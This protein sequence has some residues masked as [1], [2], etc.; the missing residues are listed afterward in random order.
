MRIAGTKAK[1]RGRDVGVGALSG[2]SAWER[3]LSSRVGKGRLEARLGQGTGGPRGL[4]ARPV[5]CETGRRGKERGAWLGF[6]SL[7]G[8]A[9]PVWPCARER[10]EGEEL[11]QAGLLRRLGQG[12]GGPKG[13][14]ASGLAR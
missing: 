11:G 13:G 1:G 3:L 6:C 9:G 12:T 5:G 4:R 2:G 14:V 10:A 8:A 7:L